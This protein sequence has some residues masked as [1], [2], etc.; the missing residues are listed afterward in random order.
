MQITQTKPDELRLEG[1]FTIQA[2]APVWTELSRHLGSRSALDIDL[3]GV[4]EIDTAGVQIML[5]L[6]REAQRGDKA[7]R[8]TQHSPAVTR[9]LDL[10]NLGGALQA[11]ATFVWS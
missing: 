5:A 4:S 3:S 9:V 11:P 6:Q 10:F 1:E 2:A 7:L 8:W